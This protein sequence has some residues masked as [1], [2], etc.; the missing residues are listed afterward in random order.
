M[1]IGHNRTAFN[2]TGRYETTRHAEQTRS[3]KA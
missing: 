3:A 2:F 1:L